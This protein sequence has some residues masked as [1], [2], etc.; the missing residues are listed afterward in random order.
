MVSLLAAVAVA[1]FMLMKCR[2]Y[3]ASCWPGVS[4]DSDKSEL[5]DKISKSYK[6]ILD[7]R[8][9][10]QETGEPAANGVPEPSGSSGSHAKAT[11]ST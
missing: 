1:M 11:V 7:Q 4:P 10:R 2:T 8:K 5:P 9:D 6:T 3:V